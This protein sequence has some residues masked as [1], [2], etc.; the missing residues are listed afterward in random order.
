MSKAGRT[1]DGNWARY[2]YGS[3]LIQPTGMTS[4]QMLHGF[5]YVYEGFWT[6]SFG[7]SRQS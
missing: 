6:R 2:N 4:E 3:A 1:L 5:K 7:Y